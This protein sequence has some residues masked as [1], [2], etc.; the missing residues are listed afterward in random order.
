MN[1]KKINSTDLTS[2]FDKLRQKGKSPG[3][4]V[5]YQKQV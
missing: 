1:Q 4:Y 3:S 2:I 5:S